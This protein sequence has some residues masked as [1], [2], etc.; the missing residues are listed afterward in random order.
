MHWGYD[1]ASLIVEK[2]GTPT[3]IIA[4]DNI[5]LGI[6]SEC[7]DVLVSAKKQ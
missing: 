4:F 7:S 2:A 6:R 5:H 3:V 1:I